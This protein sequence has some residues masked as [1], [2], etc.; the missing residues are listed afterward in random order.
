MWTSKWGKG[1]FAATVQERQH[2]SGLGGVGDS[3]GDSGRVVGEGGLEQ[4]PQGRILYLFPRYGVPP[5][6]M[7]CSSGTGRY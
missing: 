1:G 7:Y 5:S 6:V 4:F 3:L 2:W